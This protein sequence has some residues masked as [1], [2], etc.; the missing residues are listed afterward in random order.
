MTDSVNLN[1][2]VAATTAAVPVAT[3]QATTTQAFNSNPN[4]IWAASDPFNLGLNTAS[5]SLF[6]TSSSSNFSDDIMM[7]GIDFNS[8]SYD[9][10]SQSIVK[11]VN[12]QQQQV[13]Q[14]VPPQQAQ[15]Q[16]T[17]QIG[18]NNNAQNISMLGSDQ[19][20]QPNVNLSEL[21]NYL[22]KKDEN[23]QDKGIS[24]KTGG[25]IVGG[26]APLADK[27][28][29]AIKNPSVLKSINWKQ[30]AVTCPIIALA[31]FGIGSLLSNVFGKK[32]EQPQQVAQTQQSATQTVTTQPQQQAAFSQ[33]PQAA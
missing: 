11:T 21:D 19:P 3:T 4:S 20:Q 32:T 18:Q 29:S 22:V 26:L 7:S 24:W 16:Q 15:T 17:P 2:N 23:Q 1:T 25:A 8:L 33:L 13:A 12:P 10:N 14:T 5:N 6:S 28:L 31:G 9:P 30:M 27:L